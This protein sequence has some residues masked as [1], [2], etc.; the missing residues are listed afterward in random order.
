[1]I[2][3]ISINLVNKHKRIFPKV[4]PKFGINQKHMAT[5]HLLH[6]E[7]P[8]CSQELF[9][10]VE[11]NYAQFISP[12]MNQTL[13]RAIASENHTSIFSAL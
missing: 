1:M 7:R 10:N 5:K 8:F 11:L 12:E 4:L 6:E 2:V 9:R 13:H 3:K